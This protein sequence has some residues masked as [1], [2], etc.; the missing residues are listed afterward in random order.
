MPL[1]STIYEHQVAFMKEFEQQEGIAFMLIH[2][3]KND[4]YYY[5]TSTRLFEFW[6]RAMNGGRKSFRYDELDEA[7]QIP[8]LGSSCIHYL[9]ILKKDLERREVE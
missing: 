2:Y 8:L 7:Y 3:K 9:D 6:E 5:L 1:I 4:A